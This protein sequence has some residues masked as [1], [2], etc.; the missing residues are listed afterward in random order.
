MM[1]CLKYIKEDDDLQ[2]GRT[3]EED[4]DDTLVK[5]DDDLL[6]YM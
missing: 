2:I 5:C 4:D 1:T 3:C 6:K